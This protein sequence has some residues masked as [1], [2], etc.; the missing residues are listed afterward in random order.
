[1]R[2]FQLSSIEEQFKL[3]GNVIDSRGV[4]QRKAPMIRISVAV[5]VALPL[6]NSAM[7]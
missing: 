2:Q 5:A 4:A 3:R 7:A 6:T 1:M